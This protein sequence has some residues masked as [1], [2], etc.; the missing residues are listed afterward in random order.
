MEN[1]EPHDIA[2]ARIEIMN[3][4]KLGQ[5]SRRALIDVAVNVEHANSG[6][7]GWRAQSADDKI[8][9]TYTKPKRGA[10]GQTDPANNNDRPDEEAI[11]QRAREKLERELVS[12]NL[13]TIDLCLFWY[14]NSFF[15]P[16]LT[17]EILRIYLAQILPILL[18]MLIILF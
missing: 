14:Q 9:V 17:N 1:K 7:R 11:E 8:R 3:I 13:I 16:S 6:A 4:S 12:N 10:K 5:N 15:W 2:E 18:C